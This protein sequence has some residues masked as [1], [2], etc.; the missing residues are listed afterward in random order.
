MRVWAQWLRGAE[1]VTWPLPAPA[2]APCADR[3]PRVLPR[4]SSTSGRAS[5][6]PFFAI[7]LLFSGCPRARPRAVSCAGCGGGPGLGYTSSGSPDRPRRAGTSLPRG[8]SAHRCRGCC[9]SLCVSAAAA[10]LAFSAFLLLFS[11][12]SS[13]P[14]RVPGGCR[15]RGS[16]CEIHP[17]SGPPVHVG[18]PRV[19]LSSVR[20]CLEAPGWL[21]RSPWGQVLPSPHSASTR[22]P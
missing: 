12:V 21:L 18:H 15:L 4:P 14:L 2:A 10:R 3:R 9:P 6:A 5:L 20:S 8:R 16:V 17:R 7:S 19:C 13:A 22:A 1:Q 11:Q